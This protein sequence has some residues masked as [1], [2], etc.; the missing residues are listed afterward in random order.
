MRDEDLQE[1][2][3]FFVEYAETS[4][5][6]RSNLRAGGVV[7]RGDVY[8]G[9]YV[10][11]RDAEGSL[12]GVAVHYWT[13]GVMVQAPDGPSVALLEC[14]RE[15]CD[16][17]VRA[18]L[19]PFEQVVRARAVLGLEGTPCDRASREF[20]YAIE[21]EGVEGHALL[22][23]DGVVARRAA[24]EDLDVLARW[25]VAYMSEAL[26]MEPSE[27]D[28]EQAR[29][30]MVRAVDERRGWV[31]ELRGELV[32]Y[33]GNNA[34]VEEMHQLGGVW[35]PPEHRCRGYARAVISQQLLDMRSDGRARAILF[36]DEE[37][38]AAQ[39]AYEAIGFEKIGLFGMFIGF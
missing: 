13:G 7:D 37:N 12:C 19:G 33:T 20:L 38:V 22:R 27:V 2:E 5:F 30:V 6:Q 16:R 29:G 36:T 3:S 34:E 1:L 35:T 18:L 21:L 17:P 14:L 39:R 26:W 10:G 28:V 23:E 31:L 11:E 4:M 9:T 8:Q 24:R 15:A 32:A 25:R